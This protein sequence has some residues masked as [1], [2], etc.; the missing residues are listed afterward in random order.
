MTRGPAKGQ[1]PRLYYHARYYDPSL[2]RF[3]SADSIVPGAASGKGGAGT[4]DYDDQVA[5]RPLTVDF[6]E[7]GFAQGVSGENAFTLAKGRLRGRP[8]TG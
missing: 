6:H 8:G 5:L 2:G 7:P 4:V 3:I 1:R